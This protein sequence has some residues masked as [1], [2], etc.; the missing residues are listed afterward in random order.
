MATKQ[1]FASPQELES[2][3]QEDPLLKGRRLT[4]ALTDRVVTRFEKISGARNAAAAV[5]F[6]PRSAEMENASAKDVSPPRGTQACAR[7]WREIVADLSVESHPQRRQC[8]EGPL[9][10]IVPVIWN[11]W[12]VA[13]CKL[14]SINNEAEAFERNLELL[15]ILVENFVAHETEL[16]SSCYTQEEIGGMPDAAHGDRGDGSAGHHPQLVRAISYIKA[17]LSDTDLTVAGIAGRLKMNATYLAHLFSTR[18]GVRMSRFIAKKRMEL[19]KRLL[20]TT[21]WQIKRIAFECGYAN[22]DWF[23]HV[24]HDYVGC[25]PGEYRRRN[26]ASMPS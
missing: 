11:D 16:L 21:Q 13:G 25:P 8:T 2:I 26:A 15:N 7:C 14:V 22:P 24:F 18:M 5:C 23:S 19:A 9:C 17:H 4:R 1:R 10:G 6:H 3:R 20:S 12:C